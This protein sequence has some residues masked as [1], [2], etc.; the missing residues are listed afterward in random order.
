MKPFEIEKTPRG[1]DSYAIPQS[2]AIYVVA[3]E[4]NTAK[5]QAVPGGAGSVMFQCVDAAGNQAPF[6]ADFGGTAT[7]AAADVTDGSGSEPNPVHRSLY[8]VTSISVISPAACF[9]YMMFYG[10]AC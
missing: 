3:L 6:W 8:G 9:V 1:A 4:A 5:S 10:P 7:I 2:D